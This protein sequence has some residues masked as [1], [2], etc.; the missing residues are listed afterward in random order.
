MKLI[1]NNWKRI[2]FYLLYIVLFIL[3]SFVIG[4]IMR[5]V[6]FN[7]RIT[8]YNK[9]VYLDVFALLS[10]IVFISTSL[11]TMLSERNIY[12]FWV[13]IVNKILIEPKGLSFIDLVIYAFASLAFSAMGFLSQ[14][15]EYVIGGFIAG[16]VAVGVLFFRMVYVYY[17]ENREKKKL[18]K[19]LLFFV[20]NREKLSEIFDAYAYEKSQKVIN[21]EEIKRSVCGDKPY[22][23]KDWRELVRDIK[24]NSES[25][26]IY[27]KYEK[28]ILEH[29]NLETILTELHISIVR[30]G[31]AHKIEG[32]TDDMDL[33]FAYIIDENVDESVRQLF[34][35]F[36]EAA[37]EELK[38]ICPL[39]FEQ[40]VNHHLA[41]GSQFVSYFTP[42]IIDIHSKL[43]EC[44]MRRNLIRFWNRYLSV[45]QEDIVQD[46]VKRAN[47]ESVDFISSCITS[48][49]YNSTGDMSEFEL[50]LFVIKLLYE[51]QKSQKTEMGK[52]IIFSIKNAWET[53]L[54]KYLEREINTYDYWLL[55]TTVEN[56][57]R[58][59]EI[60]PLMLMGK[61]IAEAGLKDEFIGF[62]KK[63]IYNP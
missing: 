4:N 32:L 51:L 35:S 15:G 53:V 16:I 47:G 45:F 33:L 1:K 11:M 54:N 57:S 34:L 40:I 10:S 39:E 21:A 5:C 27:K 18:R 50:V 38:E 55:L 29:Y 19:E 59:N 28:R 41:S 52:T 58:A 26:K 23:S 62:L 8:T 14:H 30:C 44:R 61:S 60:K 31:T 13:D 20:N 63:D 9:S 36:Y 46:I 24:D 2:L 37:Y 22:F 12:V 7:S 43:L 48:L 3:V 6:R 49:L 17:G 42:I 56:D 25:R